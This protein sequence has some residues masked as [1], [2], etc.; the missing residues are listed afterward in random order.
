M[1]H[2]HRARA[3]AGRA[4]LIAAL[5]LACAP[6]ARAT[7]ACTA[8]RHE[9]LTVNAGREDWTS[10]RLKIQPDDVILV[11]AGGRLTVA[12]DA[13]RA[14]SPRGLADGAGALEMKVG[15]GTVVPV[16]TRWFGSF[17][18]YGTL[19]FRVAAQRRA[20]LAGSYQVNL[21]VI[22]AGAFPEA[23]KLDAE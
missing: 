17:R 11:Y 3:T 7:Q 12:G 6:H 4:A 8:I 18:D 2:V 21:V 15:T 22:P 16:G 1:S 19:S 13:R 23:V 14:T 10:A 9:I 5:A 20:E